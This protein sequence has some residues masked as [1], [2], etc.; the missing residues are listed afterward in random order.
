MCCGGGDEVAIQILTPGHTTIPLPHP[1]P[2]NR[3]EWWGNATNGRIYPILQDLYGGGVIWWFNE[4]YF[5]INTLLS[6]SWKKCVCVRRGDYISHPLCQKVWRIY[7]VSQE[8]VK[9][10][11]IKIFHKVAIAEWLHNISFGVFPQNFIFP[12]LLNLNPSGRK[13]RKWRGHFCGATKG[14]KSYQ[15]R[16][17]SH[18]LPFWPHYNVF[19]S[20]VIDGPI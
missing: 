6:F 4:K 14:T 3:G 18:T 16:I 17:H 1:S 9:T 8:N 11:R 19:N 2:H 10:R 13:W 7:R 5:S 20:D 15:W 12:E